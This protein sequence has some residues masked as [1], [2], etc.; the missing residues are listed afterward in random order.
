MNQYIYPDYYK[1]FKCKTGSCRSACCKGW[2]VSVTLEEYFRVINLDCDAL[3]RE[4]LDRG[5]YINLKPTSDHYA[6]IRKDYNGDCVFHGCDGLCEIHKM[7]GEKAIPSVCNFY[8]RNVSKELALEKSCSN[9]CEKVLEMLFK[10]TNPIEFKNEETHDMCIN[11]SK[12]YIETRK[13]IIDI[14]QTRTLSF[15]ERI[16]QLSLK[17]CPITFTDNK[18]SKNILLDYLKLYKESVVAIEIIEK[19][20]SVDNYGKLEEEIY[21]KIPDFDI[22]MEKYIVNHIFFT[23]YPYDKLNG[24]YDYMI[25][26]LIGVYEL[27]KYVSC[28]LM[29]DKNTKEDLV[30]IIALLYRLIGHSDFHKM[31]GKYLYVNV[32]K[33]IL[34]LL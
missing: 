20:N 11:Y 24:K 16:K 23:G 31:I 21:E 28:F 19:I 22:Y 33:D 5:F 2:N 10:N 29:K 6:I 18:V 34:G 13:Q 30:D 17:F 14:I 8:P 12:E 26:S 7:Y 25:H 27:T 3:F 15:K 9:S 4:K 1:N 32:G